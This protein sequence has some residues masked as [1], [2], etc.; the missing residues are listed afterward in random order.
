MAGG[1]A[2]GVYGLGPYRI[3]REKLANSLHTLYDQLERSDI[4]EET[5]R[6]LV[7]S[8][9]ELTDL[10]K[11]LEMDTAASVI[12]QCDEVL[13]AVDLHVREEAAS[14]SLALLALRGRVGEVTLRGLLD[15]IERITDPGRAVA[16]ARRFVREYA[17]AGHPDAGGGEGGP[18]PV[19]GAAEVFACLAGKQCDLPLPGRCRAYKPHAI[20]SSRRCSRGLS[21]GAGRR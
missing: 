3:A 18:A 10:F 5:R 20:A 6:K 1:F 15:D 8:C 2:L 21:P 11:T 7:A 9:R 14:P 12:G 19:S 4:T 16:I 13:A 17:S